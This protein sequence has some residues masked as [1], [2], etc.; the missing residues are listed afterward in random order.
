M[1][2]WRLV[3]IYATFMKVTGEIEVIPPDRLTDAV[4]RFGNYLTVRK[5]RTES[6]TVNFPVLSR[7]EKEA[8]IRKTSVV[9]ICPEDGGSAGN[10]AMWRHKD[11]HAVAVNT[12]AFSLVGD[13]HLDHRNTMEDHLE[14]YPGDFIPV[15]NVSAIW[16]AGPGARTH[17]VQRPFA[18]LNPTS[19][20]SFALR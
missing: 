19:I 7:E 10:R 2:D 17:S 3:E 18:L 20:L 6:L 5:A 8:T 9:L 14:R 13:V 1:R 4:N 15:T 11:A 12:E 16:V